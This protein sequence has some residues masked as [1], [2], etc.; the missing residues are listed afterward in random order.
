[1]MQTRFRYNFLLPVLLF[2]FII[3]SCNNRCISQTLSTNSTRAIR[4]F[5]EGNRNYRLLS[6]EEAKKK[7]KKATE[8]DQE[9]IEAFI[10][11]GE[12]N[13]AIEDHDAAL[14]AYRNAIVIDS[15]KYPEVYFFTGMVQFEIQQYEESIET[16]SHFLA[17]DTGNANRRRDADFFI[18]C[19]EFAIDAMKNPIPFQPR[20]L[21]RNINTSG[22][23]Y[24]NAVSSDE[25]LLYFTG[26]SPQS[27]PGA[28]GD[29]F[30]YSTR[31]TIHDD[32]NP[33]QLVG[34]PFNAGG[35]EGALTITLDRRYVLFA[36]CQWPEGFGSC[37]IY[38]AQI[39]DGQ[40]GTPQNLGPKV[41]GSAWDS[42]PSMAPDG[43]TL[44]FTSNRAGGFG[45]SDIWKSVLQDDGQWSTPENLGD[46]INTHGYE[47]A[48][49]IHADGTT[50][51][52]SS[53]RH[54]G[55]G[56]IDLFVSKT[57]EEGNWSTP[58]NLGYPVNTPGDE[59]N[60]IVNARGAKAYISAKLSEGFGGF[61]IYEF[62]LHEDV[63]PVPSTYLKG[64]VTDAKTNE[65]VEAFFVL[66]NLENDEEVVRSFSDKNTGE[67]LLCIP[68][69]RDYALNVSGE[70]YM[71]YSENFS[72]SG[73]TTETKPFIK[74]ISLSPIDVGETIILR[75]I[76]FDTGKYNL[77][78]ESVSELKKLLEFMEHN[79]ALKIEIG[80]HTDNVGGEA[81]NLELSENRAKSVFDFLT[82]R[83]IEPSRLTYRGF[84]YSKP[85]ATNDTQDGRAKNRRTEIS[86]TGISE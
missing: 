83:G 17:F 82:Q 1:M 69:N 13:Q 30:F 56:G 47:M 8:I 62:D 76:F 45:N 57:D 22:D 25:L 35:N 68:T 31:N 66:I 50:L 73:F 6:Y 5:E 18:R 9:F 70:G 24:I 55:M 64:I 53:D 75:N 48:P 49:F 23:E 43:R 81:Y 33:A 38:V 80:G 58:V 37:D 20:N 71:F 11:L 10:L 39:S 36:G 79:P 29:S 74:N 42:Q 14:K 72:L 41:N 15:A 3:H 85:I 7:L 34:T 12:V 27:D 60:I 78:P 52:F 21:K 59:I 63:R 84:G 44:Y 28:A 40:F 65:P 61:D 16:L 54:V 51:Y 2:F 4:L 26:S 46:V 86:I 77:K 32:W 67:F 19:S